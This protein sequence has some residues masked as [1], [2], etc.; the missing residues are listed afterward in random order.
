MKMNQ[1]GQV[2]I[3]KAIRELFGL[4]PDTVIDVEVS[5]DG[6]LLKPVLSSTD[7][8]MAWLKN[9]HGDEMATLTNDQIFHLMH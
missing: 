5:R 6:I 8:V 1:K 4:Q 9:E 2:T 7:D 3:P